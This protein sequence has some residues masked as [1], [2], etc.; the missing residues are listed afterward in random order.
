[1]SKAYFISDAHLGLGSKEE[2]K[3]K[4]GRLVAFLDSI[5]HDA[6]Q[7]FIV[8]DLFDAWFEY[9]TVIP[10][11]YYRLLTKLGEL[12]DSKIKVHYLVGNH[13]YW[14]RDFFSGELNVK[15]Y[16]EAFET[17]IDGKRYLIHHG[18]GLSL[19]DSGYKIL[20]IILRN[21]FA[22]WLYTWIHPDIGIKLARFS[23]KRSR[24]YTS[25]KHY[26]EEDGMMRFASEKIR[27]G[28][29]TVIMGHRHLPVMRKID[30]GIYINLGDWIHHN[31]YA[32]A[33][34]GAV[35]LKT[36]KQ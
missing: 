33:E 10:K 13:D 28:I 20:K 36:W 35:S 26:G 8:G 9:R 3:E 6:S 11:G 23:S 18:D 30:H 31:T 2:E 5:Q 24:D 7:L 34:N 19:N 4:E 21:R 12:T 32:E 14:I 16:H 22:I 15:I 29:D 25:D 27:A 1:M 17:V